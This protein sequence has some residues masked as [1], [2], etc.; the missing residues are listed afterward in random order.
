VKPLAAFY[1]TPYQ[2]EGHEQWRRAVRLIRA[3]TRPGDA[4]FVYSGFTRVAYDY[5]AGQS[6]SDPNGWVP[7]VAYPASSDY[8]VSRQDEKSKRTELMRAL[9]IV[10]RRYTRV[11]LVLSHDEVTPQSVETSQLIRKRL[12]ERYPRAA[13]WPFRSVR[14]LLYER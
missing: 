12:A 13:V 1:R 8:F 11:W 4:V 9:N 14:V 5:Y 2:I 3:E 7:T 10:P 6:L